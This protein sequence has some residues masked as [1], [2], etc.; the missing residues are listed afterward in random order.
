MIE[1]AQTF[2]MFAILAFG[3]YIEK[4]MKTKIEELPYQTGQ[5]TDKITT[6][7][8]VLD[9]IA[10]LLNEAMQAVGNSG[11]AHPPSSPIEALLTSFLGNIGQSNKHATQTQEWEILENDPQTKNETE[12][13]LD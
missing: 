10:D 7:T 5:I 9:D 11:I 2:A 3:F 4:S 1:Y 8:E 13:Q 6:C 12:N